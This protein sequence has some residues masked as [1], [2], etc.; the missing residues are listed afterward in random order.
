MKTIVIFSY[1]FGG[2]MGT[3]LEPKLVIKFL[4]EVHP[5]NHVWGVGGG[6]VVTSM[7]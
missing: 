7:G 5:L 3:H 1:K 6:M 4:L 2:Q